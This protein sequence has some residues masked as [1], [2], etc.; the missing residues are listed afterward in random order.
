MGVCLPLLSILYFTGVHLQHWLGQ[1]LRIK[2]WSHPCTHLWLLCRCHFHCMW[3]SGVI[4]LWANGSKAIRLLDSAGLRLGD[5]A[6]LWMFLLMLHP[7]LLHSLTYSFWCNMFPV[8][9][10]V[11]QAWR[12]GI[13]VS[14]RLLICLH[15]VSFCRILDDTVF[16]MLKMINLTVVLNLYPLIFDFWTYSVL[17][18][19]KYR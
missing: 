11:T 8:S 6:R 15:G 2:M 13:A 7:E 3:C 4:Q 1:V 5:A 17:S 10:Y 12:I 9:F 16:L 18:N 14:A 19:G